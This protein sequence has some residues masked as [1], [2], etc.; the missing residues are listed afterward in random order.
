MS[1]TP[2]ERTG[3]AFAMHTRSRLLI[4]LL[5]L[6][7]VPAGAQTEA[8]TM[9]DTRIRE[10]IALMDG[11][12]TRTGLTGAQSPR[13]YLWTDAFAVCNYLSLA[14]ASGEPQYREQ[15]LQ[16]VAQVHH[17]LGRH[18]DD[19]SRSGWISGLD[20]ADG[21][22]HPTRGGL[23]IGKPQPERGPREPYD[24]R[25][26]WDRDGQYFHYLTRWMHALDQVA[27]STRNPVFNT[28]ARELSQAAYNGFTYQPAPHIE[29]R[30]MAW[31]MSIDLSRILVP[32][33]GQHD[34]LEGYVNNLQ[35]QSTAAALRQTAGEPGLEAE[36]RQYAALLKRTELAT[37]DPLGLGG[38]L[39]D[40]WRLQQL[41][42]Q[43][44]VPDAQLLDRLLQAA[45][46]G[47]GHYARGNELAQPA[48]YRLA[49][50]ELGLAIGL[51]ALERMHQAARE[52]GTGARLRAQLEELMRYLPLRD[53]I[54]TFWRNPEHQRTESWKEHEDINAVML[55]TALVPAGVL[56]L[57][58]VDND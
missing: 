8:I 15:A 16:L 46:V 57:L 48:R 51:H 32:S 52:T 1:S 50:R 53:S 36:T 9:P 24:E 41:M 11:F 12:A 45:A 31:K 27:R 6:T 30:S 29:P 58:P 20:E 35:L 49:F 38:L 54:E 42:Q 7:Q 55:A 4:L 23:R 33:M 13:R 44:A 18:R 28:W 14:R 3:P 26:E 39:L 47:L 25:S 37:A 2:D 40:A 34:P 21:E 5:T 10:A 17:V 56:D 22:R 19:D 43:G